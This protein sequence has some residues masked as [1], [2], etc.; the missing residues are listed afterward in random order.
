VALVRFGGVPDVDLDDHTDFADCVDGPNGGLAGGCECS[1]FDA[2][3]DV[4][5]A[6]Y[7]IWQQGVG[8]EELGV[9]ANSAYSA[10]LIAS[11]P[12]IDDAELV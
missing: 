11:S 12:E 8:L 9:F 7:A 3:S 10:R 1:D 2:D 4:D 6:D 5:L